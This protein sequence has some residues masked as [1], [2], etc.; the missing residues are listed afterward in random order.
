MINFLTDG[1]LVL[2]VKLLKS[3][4]QNAFRFLVQSAQ[5]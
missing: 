4:M 5:K 2:W 3:T 1:T